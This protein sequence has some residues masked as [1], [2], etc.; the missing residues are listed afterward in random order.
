MISVWVSERNHFSTLETRHHLGVLK[1]A[2]Q[3]IFYW[4]GHRGALKLNGKVLFHWVGHEVMLFGH[5]LRLR[6]W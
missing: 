3:T 1:V 6:T 4:I 2:G 5:R